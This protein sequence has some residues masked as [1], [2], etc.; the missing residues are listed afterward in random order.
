MPPEYRQYRWKFDSA[1]FA[2][3]VKKLTAQSVQEWAALMA[4]KAAT[5]SSWRNMD[6]PERNP[7]PSMA[8]FLHICNE[9]DLDPRDFFC[10]DIPEDTNG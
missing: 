4:V 10:L 9:L 8:N 7:H 2:K 3:A 1:K 6:K 5:L